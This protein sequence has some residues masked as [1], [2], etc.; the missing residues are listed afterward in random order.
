MRAAAV[1]APVNKQREAIIAD[2]KN[3]DCLREVILLREIL[4]PPLAMRRQTSD[5]FI[6]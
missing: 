5:A 1:A 2:L 4:G 3:R 6:G